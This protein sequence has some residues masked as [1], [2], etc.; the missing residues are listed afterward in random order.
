[1][2][3]LDT[4]AAVPLLVADHTAHTALSRWSSGRVLHLAG[5]AA[6]ETY[7]VLT[8]LPGD[9]RLLPSDAATLLERRFVS[10]LALPDDVAGTLPRVLADLDVSGGAVYDALVALA[11][12][13]HGA[14]LVTRDLRARDTYERI[15]VPV[16]IVS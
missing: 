1:M 8:R 9:L 13:H 2:F 7:S 12:Q 11:A 15:G 14:I 10:M 6:A 3:A 5:H 4:S 16:H